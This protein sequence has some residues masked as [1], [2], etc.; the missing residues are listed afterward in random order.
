MTSA[1]EAS[2]AAQTEREGSGEAHL[3][4][5]QLRELLEKATKGPWYHYDE[6]FRPQFGKRRVT[7]IQRKSDGLTLINWTGFDGL[8]PAAR[9][10]ANANAALIVA[11]VSSLPSLLD[12]LSQAREALQKL[13]VRSPDHWSS[14]AREGL[15]HASADYAEGYWNALGDVAEAARSALHT[16]GGKDHGGL[17][18]PSSTADAACSQREAPEA[19]WPERVAYVV[20]EGDGFWRT[21][22]GCHESEDGY[23]VGHYPTSTVLGCKLGGGCGECGGLGAIWDDTDYAAMADDFAREMGQQINDPTADAA[24]E[25][26]ASTLVPEQVKP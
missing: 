4:L 10:R 15:G 11:A 26:K 17:P 6:V 5:S 7:E 20:G 8:R 24:C 13:S 12:Q 21:C 2:V 19:H 18:G 22:S 23:D 9:R 16:Q 1:S 14:P 25:A 3:D